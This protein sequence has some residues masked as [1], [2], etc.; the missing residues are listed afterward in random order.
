MAD[1]PKTTLENSKKDIAATQDAV[2]HQDPQE[3][4]Q[5]Q[6]QHEP[7][8]QVAPKENAPQQ[9]SASKLAQ[10]LGVSTSKG[11]P[12]A[13]S[14][15]QTPP[16]PPPKSDAPPRQK[17]IAVLTSGGDSAGMNAAVRSVVR[18]GIARGCATY[19]I[20]EGWEGLVRGNTRETPG[21]PHPEPTHP[22]GTN[23]PPPTL[24]RT[25]SHVHLPPS[26]RIARQNK[27]EERHHN[28]DAA[29]E[30]LGHLSYGYGELL[31]S[32][33]AEGEEESI[34]VEDES[35]DDGPASKSL[36]GTYI[37]RVGWDDVRG[38]LGEGGTL[39]GSSRCPSFRTR[40]GRLQAAQN[41][42]KFGIDCLAVCGGDGSLTGA[43]ML[44][45]E[46]PSL[47]KELLEN[48]RILQ[49]EAE[50]FRHL[51]IVGLVGSIDNDM[52]MTDL[53]IGGLTA[54]HRI[55]EAVDSI[56]S[57]ASSHSR[58]FVVEVMGRH[59][60]WLALL[61]GMATGADYIF[62]PERPS[63]GDN[64]QEEMCDVL[65]AHRQVG[66]RKSIVIV[67]EGALDR[68]LQ[69]IK[70]E[71]IKNVLVDKLGLDTR[72]TTLGHTQR[73]G[74][75]CAYDR[76]LATL[77]GVEAVEALLSATPDTPSYMIGISEN[78]ITRVPLLKAVAQ[79]SF[80]WPQPLPPPY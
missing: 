51:N 65:R 31:R 25:P 40:E 76:I 8:K 16:P 79:V 27:L 42:I 64:W 4:P 41:L 22:P 74:A 2:V 33:S 73:G 52:A 77:Q 1:L 59:C 32:G 11:A 6:G 75:P 47:V 14:D 62:I 3:M 28:H 70:G 19:V 45:K 43:D 24:Q 29:G 44:R 72:V 7:S 15:A 13:A 63:K 49:E 60:G 10:A 18:M 69:P 57:T 23:V 68:N 26:Q 20:R 56:S 46:W 80:A 34:D 61:A 38:W 9:T 48:N 55:C 30:P 39:I 21:T 78:K 12:A 35:N 58:A 54:L 67:A 71:H 36:K 53:T 50:T 37:V 17:K 5:K 66:K